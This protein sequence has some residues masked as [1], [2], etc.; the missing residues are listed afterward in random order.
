MFA[1]VATGGKQYRLEKGSR[2][3][4]E[5]IEGERGAEVVLNDVLMIGQEEKVLIGRPFLKGCSVTAKIV[6]Q[7]RGEK[8]I[9][10]KK[11]KRHGKRLKKGHRQN[12]TRLEVISIE[13]N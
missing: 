7:Y 12:L 9:I 4:I 1:V 2:V 10:F 11:L 5:Q 8:L 3:S 13:A 6:E